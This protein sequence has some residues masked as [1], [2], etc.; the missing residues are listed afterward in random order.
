MPKKSTGM[1]KSHIRGVFHHLRFFGHFRPIQITVGGGGLKFFEV[2][3]S[4]AGKKAEM[5]EGH[6]VLN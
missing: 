6:S 1:Q 5:G 2:C 3:R 4:I